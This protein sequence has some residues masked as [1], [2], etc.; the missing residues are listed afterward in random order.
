MKRIIAVLC[1]AALVIS[2]CA[3][4]GQSAAKPL[5]E[6]F[7]EIK[8]QVTLAENIEYND[9]AKLDRYY[10]IAPEEVAEFAGCVSSSGTD[11]EEIIL[12]KAADSASAE[13]IKGILEAKYN[14]KLNENKNYNPEQAAIIEKCKVEQNDLYVSMIISPSAETITSIYKKAIG[15]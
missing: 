13:R 5:S 9:V 2:L 10:G 4:S 3:C 1:A 11:Q 14:A 12:I 15:Q 8:S 7:E 6:V